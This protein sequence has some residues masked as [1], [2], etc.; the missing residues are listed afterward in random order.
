MPPDATKAIPIAVPVKGDV[1][2]FGPSRHLMPRSNSV[3]CGGNVLQKS[4]VAGPQIFREL[5]KPKA[6]ADSYNLNRVT[7]VPCEFNVRR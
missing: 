3:A 4:K 5:T 6:I 7:E 1:I 2:S